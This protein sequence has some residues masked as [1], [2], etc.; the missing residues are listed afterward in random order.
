MKAIINFI[1]KWTG[2]SKILDLVNGF[3]T[4]IGAISL[5]LSG[6]A[7]LTQR[8]TSLTDLASWLAFLKG[9]PLSPGWVAVSAGI[10]AWGLAHKMEKS[11][12]DAE[13]K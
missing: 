9:L 5:I 8:I 7:E 11:A 10:A 2:A 1:G 3:K 13:V 12:E 6:L 4:K